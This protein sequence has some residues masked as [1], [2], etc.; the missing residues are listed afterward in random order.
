MRPILV[1]FCL[2]LALGLTAAWLMIW[3]PSIPVETRRQTY[4]VCSLPYVPTFCAKTCGTCSG[5]K[6]KDKYPK[7]CLRM[8]PL[9]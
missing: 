7:R 2:L 4:D 1:L 8:I 5:S 6:C 3:G 9:G